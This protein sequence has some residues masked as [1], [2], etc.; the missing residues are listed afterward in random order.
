MADDRPDTDPWTTTF[1]PREGQGVGFDRVVFF[2]DAVI[3][4]AV[5]LM[6]VEIGVP[7]I[8]DSGSASE[9]WHA[10]V[11]KF[12]MFA[13]YVAAFAWVAFYWRANHR[14]TNTLRGMTG[15]Y[16]VV[17]LVYL[18]ILALFPLPAGMLG[19][20]WDNPVAIVIFAVFA[21]VMSAWET[22]LFI[23]ADRDSLF[24]KPVT[25]AF[26]RQSI[27]G[28]L[29]PVVGFLV[30]IPIAFISTWAAVAFW[31]VAAVSIGALVNRLLP[32]DPP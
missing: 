17:V 31:F 16:I 6:A 29:I 30:S 14:F 24:I 21:A 26:R 32:A 15:R 8:E 2:S 23:V 25:P 20:Y 19:R 13:A 4:I 10:V 28:S 1:Y 7:E 11:G 18:G 12:P 5:T 9:L 3:A 27:V 22:M